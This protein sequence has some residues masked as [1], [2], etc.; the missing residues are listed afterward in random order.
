M[1]NR[2]V[3]PGLHPGMPGSRLVPSLYQDLYMCFLLFFRL[4]AL[5]R[6]SALEQGPF[7]EPLFGLASGNGLNLG[8]CDREIEPLC[9][10]I[11]L[12]NNVHKNPKPLQQLIYF[13]GDPDSK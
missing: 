8:V 7:P 9:T 11:C 10:S 1:G 2:R 3:R 6:P 4:A 12:P 13:S 5:R